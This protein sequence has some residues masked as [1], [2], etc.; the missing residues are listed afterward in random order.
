[1]AWHLAM[2]ARVYQVH[3]NQGSARPMCSHMGLKGQHDNSSSSS[4]TTASRS[5]SW[6]L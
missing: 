2:L 3:S 1:M 4:S 6:Q 5:R